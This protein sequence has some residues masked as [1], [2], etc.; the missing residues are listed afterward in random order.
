[1]EKNMTVEYFFVGLL[2]V[3]VAFFVFKK[4]KKEKTPAGP[5]IVS[6]T[7]VNGDRDVNPRN[8]SP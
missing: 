8:P 7:G 3:L 6:G 1:M 2:V 4:V 5:V